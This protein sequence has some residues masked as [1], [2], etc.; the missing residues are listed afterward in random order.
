MYIV[1][2]VANVPSLVYLPKMSHFVSF[3]SGYFGFR[4]FPACLK[5]D[6][7]LLWKGDGVTDESVPPLH[8]SLIGMV[9]KGTLPA[10][11]N[12][13][14]HKAGGAGLASRGQTGHRG[15]LGRVRPAI[16]C[17]PPGMSKAGAIYYSGCRR[18]TVIHNGGSSLSLASELF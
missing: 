12:G 4:D 15:A 2:F 7:S 1:S 11:A 3:T 13:H 18:G 9:L 5:R 17:V 6:E 10:C 16:A 8:W 14:R